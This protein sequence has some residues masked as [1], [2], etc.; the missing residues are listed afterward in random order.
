MNDERISIRHMRVNDVTL[1]VAFAGESNSGPTVLLVH[2]FPD[3]HRLWRQ[4][5]PVLARAGFRVVAPDTRG[6]GDSQM[7]P[8]PPQDASAYRMENLVADLAGLL[9]ALKLEQVLLV[10]HD[11]GAIQGW[12]FVMAHPQRVQKFIALSVGHPSA[13]GRCFWQNFKSLYMRVIQIR[14]IE[15]LVAARDFALFKLLAH[16]PAESAHW[17]RQCARPGRLSAGLAYYRANKEVLLAIDYPPVRVPVVGIWSDGDHFLTERQMINSA[18]WCA[19]GFHYERVNGANH[20]LPLDA[21]EQVN[22]LLLKH[23]KTS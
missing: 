1:N 12:R 18:H 10:A 3:D 22:F 9:D 8:G 14:G 5:I 17:V 7:P 23:L 2:G 15:R 4:Q 19:A 16:Y 21:A 13:Y 6:C 11:W 20:W